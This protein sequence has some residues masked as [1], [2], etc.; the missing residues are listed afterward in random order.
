V[1]LEAM[2]S[3]KPVIA[4]G[5]GGVLET[6]VPLKKSGNGNPTGMFF[7]EQS[8]EALA[9]AVRD[10]EAHRGRF[11]PIRIHEHAKPFDRQNFKDKIH[12]FVMSKV[13]EFKETIHA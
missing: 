6:V 4:Y 7:Y 3:G 1:P 8:P 10:F 9:E 11:D 5:K 12:Q 2:A 13:Q